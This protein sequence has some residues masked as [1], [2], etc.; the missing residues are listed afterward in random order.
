[1]WNTYDTASCVFVEY[2]FIVM[3]LW[4][5]GAYVCVCLGNVSV[6]DYRVR[7][8]DMFHLSLYNYKYWCWLQLLGKRLWASWIIAGNFTSFSMM[9]TTA[10]ILITFA[11]AFSGHWFAF[12]SLLQNQRC[13][14]CIRFTV[15]G[16]VYYSICQLDS[17]QSYTLHF[18]FVLRFKTIYLVLQ[19]I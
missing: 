6:C 3:N 18:V 13:E 5:Y 1:M 19:F 12:C 14:C 9:Y 7:L 17:N 8:L 2:E 16:Q 15:I 4:I 10:G 11:E